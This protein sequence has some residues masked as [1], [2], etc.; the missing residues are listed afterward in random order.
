MPGPFPLAVVLNSAE[1]FDLESVVRA[2]S[3]SQA[4]VFRA[5]LALRAVAPD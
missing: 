2:G 3:T 5:G 4:L 1:R